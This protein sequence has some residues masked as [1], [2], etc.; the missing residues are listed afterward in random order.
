[1]TT[2][3]T[4]RLPAVLDT[5]SVHDRNAPTIEFTTEGSGPP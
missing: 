2:V 5:A 3:A 1:M 4:A